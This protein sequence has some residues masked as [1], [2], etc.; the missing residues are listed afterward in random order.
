[1]DFQ[2]TATRRAW[3]LRTGAAAA[4]ATPL[5][6]AGCTVET[7]DGLHLAAENLDDFYETNA[8]P[9]VFEVTAAILHTYDKGTPRCG[10]VPNL[11]HD[12]STDVSPEQINNLT[13]GTLNLVGTPPSACPPPPID[14]PT[15]VGCLGDLE[16]T[17]TWDE[18]SIKVQGTVALQP[19]EWAE[20]MGVAAGDILWNV[21]HADKKGFDITITA[22]WLQG[23][24][25]QQTFHLSAVN[26]FQQGNQQL[27]CDYVLGTA[28][29]RS[30]WFNWRLL[31]SGIQL[32]T[33]PEES[34]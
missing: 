24:Q 4:L 7:T 33:G 32:D 28:G 26:V 9:R 8:L 13:P 16:A 34:P 6:I 5:L 3:W 18:S 11:R 10:L 31:S 20:G 23:Q 30:S 15:W 19:N 2:G 22:P 21:H 17:A 14:P 12:W 25:A 29:S 27:R 1:M